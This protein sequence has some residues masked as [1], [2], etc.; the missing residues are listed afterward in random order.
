MKPPIRIV[1]DT[2]V[3]VSGL[4]KRTSLPGLILDYIF[5]GVLI[6]V[7]EARL[8]DEYQRVLGRP[9]LQI[10]AAEAGQILTFL[11]AHGEWIIPLRLIPEPDFVPDPTDLPFAEAAVAGC[12]R[13]LVTGNPR[14]FGFLSAYDVQ[15]F[16]PAEIF[17]SVKSGL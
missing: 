16:T 14:H 6:V 9:R 12:A 8:M 5:A 1:L 10:P 17:K 13:A 7:M 2:N 3:L 4:L 11:A 15:V